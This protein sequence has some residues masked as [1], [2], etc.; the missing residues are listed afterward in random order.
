[1]FV[2]VHFDTDFKRKLFCRHQN[3]NPGP[4]DSCLLAYSVGI[5]FLIGI[6]ISQ[7]DYFAPNCG[8][9]SGGPS[10]GNKTTTEATLLS[11]NQRFLFHSD[12]LLFFFG[13]KTEISLFM[14][15]IGSGFQRDLTQTRYFHFILTSTGFGFGFGIGGIDLI[16]SGIFSGFFIQFRFILLLL[17]S[18][19]NVCSHSISYL[20]LICRVNSFSSLMYLDVIMCY[21]AYGKN[22]IFQHYLSIGAKTSTLNYNQ[23]EDSAKDST[24]VTCSQGMQISSRHL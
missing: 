18:V 22:V 17:L 12:F 19:G 11:V 2:K 4:S 23:V 14:W 3:S 15:R 9:C 13:P 16:R 5:T 8:Q 10:K 24:K 7:L 21:C 6:C 20:N 1:M